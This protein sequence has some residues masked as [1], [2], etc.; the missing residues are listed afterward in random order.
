MKDFFTQGLTLPNSWNLASPDPLRKRAAPTP[1]NQTAIFFHIP[2]TVLAVFISLLI[3]N[4]SQAMNF[5]IQLESDTDVATAE[6]AYWTFNSFQDLLDN[7]IASATFSQLGVASTFSTTGLAFDGIKGTG[8]GPI[9]E[10]ATILLFG[11]GLA[12]L[13]AWRW[14]RGKKALV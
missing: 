14:K 10:P 2:T 1:G 11:T 12:G 9:P 5:K 4:Q 13:A 3:T 7:N 8:P 6:V